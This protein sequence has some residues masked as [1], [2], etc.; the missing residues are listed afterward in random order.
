[1]LLHRAARRVIDV[2]VSCSHPLSDT[3]L[4]RRDAQRARGGKDQLLGVPLSILCCKSWLGSFQISLS[5]ELAQADVTEVEFSLRAI[6][7]LIR[8]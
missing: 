6:L 8:A 3:Q 1:M 5:I 4:S 7:S 2:S